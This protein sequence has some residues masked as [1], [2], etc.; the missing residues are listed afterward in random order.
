MKKYLGFILN[1]NK[2]YAIL[3]VPFHF[4]SYK[5][6]KLQIKIKK[7]YIKNY[8]Q[9]YNKGDIVFFD[10]IKNKVYIYSK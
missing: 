10:L 6:Q 2:N 1:S 7:Y 8:R 5:Y 9:E 4:I 3:I